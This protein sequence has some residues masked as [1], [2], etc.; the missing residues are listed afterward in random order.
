VLSANV[1]IIAAISWREQI[2]LSPAG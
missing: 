1:N 2:V